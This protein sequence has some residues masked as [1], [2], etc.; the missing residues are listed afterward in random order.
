[1]ILKRS[2]AAVVLVLALAGSG[3]AA[4]SPGPSVSLRAGYLFPSD[5]VFRGV[6]TGGLAYGLDAAV[7]L[8]GAIHLWAGAELFA[9]TGLLPVSQERTSV[10]IVPLYAGLR[11]Q[12]G[13]KSARPYIGAAAAYFLFHEENPIGAASDGGFGLLTQAGVLAKLGGAVWLDV[14]AGYR[15]CTVRADGAD[16]LEARLGGFSAGLGLAYRF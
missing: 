3:A 6:Y 15:A 1:V 9:K 4:S 10:R 13:K 11:A 12:F 7:P 16:P 5:S 14:F 2:S 8:S